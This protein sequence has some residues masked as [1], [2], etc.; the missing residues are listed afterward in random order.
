MSG[1]SSQKAEIKDFIKKQ[2]NQIKKSNLKKI[3]LKNQ[4]KIKNGSKKNQI[5]GCFL[6]ILKIAK[7]PGFDSFLIF[8]TI[9]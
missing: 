5:L 2:K 7:N 9:F 1:N 4:K 8:L 6:K 3:K